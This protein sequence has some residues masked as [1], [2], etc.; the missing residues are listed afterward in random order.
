MNKIETIDA[1]TIISEYKAENPWFGTHYNMNIYKG[2]NHGCIYCDSRSECYQVEEFDRVR[3]K[4]NA[5]I[6]I[7]RDLRSK[8]KKGIVG[9]GAMSDPYN[10]YEKELALTRGALSLIHR[11][12]FGVSLFTKS[13]LVLRDIDILTEISHHSSVL[14]AITITTADD[15]L[16]KRIEQNV[17]VSSAR[18]KAIKA[19]SDA[20]LFAG[21]LLM[22]VLPFIED[23]PE[24]IR[25]LVSLAY[26][27]NAKF[28]S[29]SPHF[30]VTLRSNQRDWYYDKLDLLF[31]GFKDKYIKTFGNAYECES[32]RSKQLWS[33][34]TQE[35]DRYG[36][37]YKME[38]IIKA[39]QKGRGI[40]QLSLF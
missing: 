33:I 35:C 40:D 23:T 36:I 11:Y 27:H 7:E 37:I 20:G 13:D 8:K 26:E 22:P 39:T 32:P 16:S 34:F 31:P 28:I 6:T 19:L 10:P 25:A 1:K 12:G 29:T 9:S 17:S 18:F 3:A 24:N 15:L 2:C 4:A 5:L 21:V 30:G 38:D 14:V